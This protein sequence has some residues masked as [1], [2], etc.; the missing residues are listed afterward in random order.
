MRAGRYRHQRGREEDSLAIVSDRIGTEIEKG[1]QVAILKAQIEEKM[2]VIARYTVDRAQ[3]VIK[4]G[5]ARLERLEAVSKAAEHVRGYIRYFGNRE[6]TLL[7]LNDE[8][9]DA[10]I[11][12]FPEALRYMQERHTASGMK[13]SDWATFEL[14]F[15]GDVDQEISERL[16]QT[17]TKSLRA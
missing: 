11:N 14:K 17:N 5:E 6:Q 10:R 16:K 3:L 4:G 8:V 12:Q 7:A 15:A 13:D 9:N 2:R 1:R